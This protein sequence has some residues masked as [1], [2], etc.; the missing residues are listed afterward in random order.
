MLLLLLL[1]DPCVLLL[2]NSTSLSQAAYPGA[3]TL[4]DTIAMQVLTT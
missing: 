3:V 4:I 1:L 2:V